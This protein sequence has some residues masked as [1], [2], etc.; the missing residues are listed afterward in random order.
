MTKDEFEKGY[1]QRSNITKSFYDEWF[2]TLP[3]ACD[4]EECKGWAAVR[5]D[6]IKDHMELYAPEGEKYAKTR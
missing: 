5:R 2:T 1:C 3:C 4:Y 6:F